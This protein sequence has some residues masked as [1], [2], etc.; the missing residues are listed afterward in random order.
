MKDRKKALTDMMS[1]DEKSGFYI[2]KFKKESKEIFDN[3]V[4]P[5][6]DRAMKMEKETLEEAA[7]MYVWGGIY[8]NEQ[9]K[10]QIEIAFIAGAKWMQEQMEKLKDFETWKEW[11]NRQQ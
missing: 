3:E 8:L 4:K 5:Q 6:I 10:Q 2:D 7:E 11:K 9:E 1:A